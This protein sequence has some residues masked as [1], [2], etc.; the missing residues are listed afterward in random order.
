MK[1]CVN[2]CNKQMTP[3]V[4]CIINVFGKPLQTELAI[5]SLMRHSGRHIDRI[6]LIN[7][8]AKISD[9]QAI[10]RKLGNIEYYETRHKQWT[11][12]VDMERLSDEDYRQSIRYQYGWERSD[13]DFIFI[14]HNDCAYHG[15]IVG[16]FLGNIGSAIAIGQIGQ[17]WNCPAW[18]SGKCDSGRYWDYR[19]SFDELKELYAKAVPPEGRVI[20]PYHLPAFH[21]TF[22]NDPW[23][24]PECRVNEWC[25]LVDLSIACEVTIPKGQ[26]PPFGSILHGGSPILDVGA[27]WFRAISRMGHQ[28]RDFPIYNY[29]KHEAG[30]PA[31]FDG[32]LYAR[33]ELNALAILKNEY[34][35]KDDGYGE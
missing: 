12:P 16:A 4:D 15:D 28:C 8:N 9:H 2:F 35:R 25:A 20:R 27:G 22:I 11:N 32:E 3:K 23:P 19:P 26:S 33:N 17:C 30:H 31:M 21:E 34:G 18:W 5:L 13:K 1:Y 7:E 24:L 29:M 14:T 10:R 6:Y